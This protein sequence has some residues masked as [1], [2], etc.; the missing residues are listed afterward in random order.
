MY[1][2]YSSTVADAAQLAHAYYSSHLMAFAVSVW[3]RGEHHHP[4]AGYS[5]AELATID[6]RRLGQ[7]LAMHAR[8]SRNL[9]QKV[10]NQLR[11]VKY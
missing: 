3:Y 10:L 7:L 6:G 11:I 5:P 1:K 8:S 4:E 9:I 2:Q